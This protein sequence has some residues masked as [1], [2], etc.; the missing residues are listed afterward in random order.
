MCGRPPLTNTPAAGGEAPYSP[1]WKLPT[2]SIGVYSSCKRAG[3]WTDGISSVFKEER[4][5]FSVCVYQYGAPPQGDGEQGLVASDR[6]ARL[7]SSWLAVKQN[8]S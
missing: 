2:I 4:I 3:E 8:P 5:T 7:D 6:H 1:R